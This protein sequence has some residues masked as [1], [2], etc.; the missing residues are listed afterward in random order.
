[1]KTETLAWIWTIGGVV[2]IVLEIFLP[3]LVVLFFGVSAIIVGALFWIGLLTGMVNAIIT[4]FI[5][6]VASV[7]ILRRFLVKI[8]PSDS[9]Y[10]YIE[11]DVDAIGTVVEVIEDVNETSDTGRI[12]YNGTSWQA[13]TKSGAIEA[14]KKAKILYRDNIS[15]IIEE[16]TEK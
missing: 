9:N 5:L 7:L 12:S 3:G 6:S 10:Q 13:K 16:Y 4:W 11:E 8:F 15:W 14:G 2:L 1:M